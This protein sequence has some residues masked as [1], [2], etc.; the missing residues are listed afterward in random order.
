MIF[1]VPLISVIKT[2]SIIGF[3][4]QMVMKL[5]S[6]SKSDCFNVQALSLKNKDMMWMHVRVCMC[7][8]VCV[9]VCVCECVCVGVCVCVWV[10]VGVSDSVCQFMC[11]SVCFSVCLRRLGILSRFW[12]K[13]V[14]FSGW[15]QKS[16]FIKKGQ[17]NVSWDKTVTV[18][19]SCVFFAYN[20]QLD[21]WN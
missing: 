5:I 4:Y 2:I 20:L 14:W 13:S 11:F 17:M 6:Y 19:K 1:Y 10:G 3:L 8:W 9:C 16:T 15:T 12:A 7:I 18:M 21:A